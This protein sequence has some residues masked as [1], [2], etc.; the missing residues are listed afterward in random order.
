MV[1]VRKFQGYLADQSNV[2]KIIAPPYDVLNTEEARHMANGNDMSFLRVNKPE[3]DLPE[4]TN[5]YD[6][7]VYK[8]GK[9]NLELFKK[10]GW[11]KQDTEERM[12]IYM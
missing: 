12:Y 4:G 3:I 2:A 11:I 6:D 7:Q 8:T 1:K 9:E 10:N 5:L